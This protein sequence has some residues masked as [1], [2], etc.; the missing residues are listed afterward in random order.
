M[1]KAVVQI[2]VLLLLT[3]MGNPD[4]Q[5]GMGTCCVLSERMEIKLLQTLHPK[6]G[7]S[8]E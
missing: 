4:G 5:Y 2:L 6:V 7:A 1:I 3:S 8:I